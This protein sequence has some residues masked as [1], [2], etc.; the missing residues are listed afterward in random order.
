M[1]LLNWVELV[2]HFYGV[3]PSPCVFGWAVGLRI[4]WTVRFGFLVRFHSGFWCC[5]V[6]RPCTTP[7]VGILMIGFVFVS[8]GILVFVSSGTRLWSNF[9]RVFFFLLVQ[10]QS[11]WRVQEVFCYFVLFCFAWWGLMWEMGC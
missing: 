9:G 1:C 10:L 7:Y 8:S 11:L 3:L 5:F 2:K 4:G 6:R